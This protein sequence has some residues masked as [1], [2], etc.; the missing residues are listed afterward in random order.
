[1]TDE[2]NGQPEEKKWGGYTKE[3]LDQSWDNMFGRSIGVQVPPP[4]A[5]EAPSG[6]EVSLSPDASGEEEQG[7]IRS[8]LG[9]A[10]EKTGQALD[11]LSWPSRTVAGGIKAQIEAQRQ[12]A[13]ERGERGERVGTLPG[14]LGLLSLADPEVRERREEITT[15][16]GGA[17][18]YFDNLKSSFPGEKFLLEFA[19]DPLNLL[20]VVPP[21]GAA[22]KTARA[23]RSASLALRAQRRLGVVQEGPLVGAKAMGR[24][25]DKVQ[26]A[27]I[28]AET[29]APNRLRTI[30]NTYVRKKDGTIPTIVKPIQMLNPSAFMDLTRA[31]DQTAIKTVTRR[32]M[33]YI[34]DNVVTTDMAGLK[35]MEA[36]KPFAYIYRDDNVFVSVKLKRP[37]AAPAKTRGR[38][39]KPV[40]RQP[41]AVAEEV[42][43]HTVFENPGK[44]T[45][46]TDQRK[47]IS[48][49]HASLDVYHKRMLDDGIKVG[50]IILGEGGHYFPRFRMMYDA[51][52]LRLGGKPVGGKTSFMRNRLYDDI[53]D[54]ILKG[55]KYFGGKSPTPATDIVETYMR[56]AMRMRVDKRYTDD[57]AALGKTF[58]DF[59]PKELTR[60]AALAR[61]AVRIGEHAV[62]NISDTAIPIEAWTK[63]IGKHLSAGEI[64][65]IR[66]FDPELGAQVEKAIGLADDVER[67]KE[68]RRLKIVADDMLELK[69]LDA[70]ELA[71]QRTA[72]LK[73]NMPENLRTIPVP[74]FGSR[75]LFPPEIVEQ[76]VREMDTGTNRILRLAGDVG[77]LMRTGQ[78]TVDAGF[79]L[80]QGAMV[81]ARSPVAWVKAAK[82]G[83]EA[84]VH[85]IA[86]Q[87]FIDQADTQEVL[88][89]YQGKLHLQSTEFTQ[90]M[91]YGPGQRTGIIAKLMPMGTRRGKVVQATLGRFTSSFEAY[92][93]AARVK[94]AQSFMPTVRAGRA[95]T[96]EVAEFVNK[97]TG[98]TSTRAL[99]VSNTLAELESGMFF[100]A[101]RYTRAMAGLAMD[102][103]QGGFKGDQARRAWLQF[104]GGTVLA[105]VGMAKGLGQ[106][107]KLD[108]RPKDQGGDGGQFMTVDFDG[109]HMGLGGKG[110]SIA[111]V[112]VKMK[113]DP[114][115][116]HTHLLRW[117]RG[118][119]APV[120]GTVADVLSGKD[121]MGTPISWNAEGAKHIGGR[122]MPFY[123]EA[124]MN[125]TPRPGWAGTI[126]E[127]FGLRSWP[128][129]FNEHRDT[130]RDDM[131]SFYPVEQ[132]DKSQKN[133]M[134]RLGIDTPVCDILTVSQ[135]KKIE[136]GRT[137]IKEI[138]DRTAELTAWSEK[139]KESYAERGRPEVNAFHR[140]RESVKQEWKDEAFKRQNAVL[141]G[142]RNPEWF[143]NEMK[144][145]NIK[146][147]GLNNGI[148]NKDG[149][150]AE[151]HAFFAE[152]R[153]LRDFT[154]LGDVARDEYIAKLVTAEDLED[155][156]GAYLFDV[157]ARKRLELEQDYGA[158]TI[159]E[160]EE[161]FLASKEAPQLWLWW[162]EDRDT[163]RP[164]WELKD[165]Y[166]AMH[167]RVKS[168]L[169]AIAMA[170][171]QGEIR[172]VQR[173]NRRSEIRNMNRHLR[174]ARER[175]RR[176]NPDVDASLRFWGYTDRLVT[177][178]GLQEFNQKWGR[179]E[180]LRQAE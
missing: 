130:L 111:R 87:R 163:I 136:Q 144:T 13:A 178:S 120:T 20:F 29:I 122:F 172:T 129:Q 104:F 161:S 151:A 50:E 34:A 160:I 39:R 17:Y 103:L 86:K 12:I 21:V 48:A 167:P 10:A 173:L 174:K 142:R 35:V 114:A 145:I 155:R 141:E 159:R 70:A 76:V 25:P 121:Y 131:A 68:L 180:N 84:L 1:M 71:S 132:M 176:T 26:Q 128:L 31:G 133:E 135:K 110:Y 30:I 73:A 63:G 123:A 66:R 82:S 166:I 19:V 147:S 175:L 81:L 94:M 47:F 74:G 158:D 112:L 154:P 96:D 89:F 113:M 3:E 78:L 7:F 51:V 9:G 95:S 117:L 56:G 61:N 80:I 105:Y 116:A 92:F 57:L 79:P 60:S 165:R 139:A 54:S 97:I 44:Y 64:G 40:A 126:A 177:R 15:D 134:E 93:D 16:A 88:R 115:N 169:D 27:A 67:V 146:A 4:V 72:A 53:E 77:D 14:P 100:L 143:K 171:A 140:D 69:R 98:V 108:P 52:K 32:K 23:S 28:E 33:Q 157:A 49:L 18:K 5:R 59:I 179:M 168:I 85:P 42:P 38:K 99:G 41:A 138:N 45:L 118:S 46:T 6:T 11:V 125:D 65:S 164:Y 55:N 62:K 8:F 137:G 162:V 24:L 101:P 106:E 119:S 150:H 37:R 91:K 22:L 109:H 2:V 149:R 107:P 102:A 43:M 75:K 152:R 148:F 83:I 90:G 170:D 124:L 58:S 127:F 156:D 36:K 153:A